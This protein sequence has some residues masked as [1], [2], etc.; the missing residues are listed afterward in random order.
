M[1]KIM[2]ALFSRL[3]LLLQYVLKSFFLTFFGGVI[4]LGALYFALD[5][6]GVYGKI[7]N[8]LDLKA[9]SPWFTYPM[10]VM[11]FSAVGSFLVG[12]IFFRKYK[13]PIARTKFREHFAMVLADEK[14]NRERQK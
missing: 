3:P 11:L 12:V 4:L 14:K 9:S 10:R 5:L 2:D 8:T 7:E 1:K 6:A 13:R